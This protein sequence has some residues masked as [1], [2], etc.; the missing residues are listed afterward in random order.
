MPVDLWPVM[1]HRMNRYRDGKHKW[2]GSV[3][4]DELTDS[5]LLEIA[6]RGRLD[7]A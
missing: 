7:G 2:W 5:L 1:R 6:D 4:T 3:V